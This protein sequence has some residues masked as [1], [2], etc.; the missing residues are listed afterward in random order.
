MIFLMCLYH[1]VTFEV[2]I[3][4]PECSENPAEN[5][6]SFEIYPVGL[7]EKLKVNL[8]LMCSCDCESPDLEVRVPS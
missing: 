5:K 6:K 3:T 8:E 7:N 1:Q 2:T 4:V